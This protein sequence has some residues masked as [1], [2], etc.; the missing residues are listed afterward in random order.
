MLLYEYKKPYI[1]LTDVNDTLFPGN[2]RH[3]DISY[4]SYEELKYYNPEKNVE[5]DKVMKDYMFILNS[6]SLKSSKYQ[7]KSSI[8]HKIVYPGMIEFHNLIHEYSKKDYFNK[9][10]DVSYILSKKKGIGQLIFMSNREQ[11]EL[12]KLES[13]FHDPRQNTRSFT[14]MAFSYFIKPFTQNE[15]PILSSSIENYDIYKEDAIVKK[16]IIKKY[17][18]KF[19]TDNKYLVI[20][21]ISREDMLLNKVFGTEMSNIVD[22][23]CL[24]QI[25]QLND[26]NYKILEKIIKENKVNQLIL[27]DLRIQNNSER[28]IYFKNY[29]DLYKKLMQKT[30]DKNL[31]KFLEENA[32]RMEDSYIEDLQNTKKM[33][34]L[35]I[36]QLI[37]HSKNIIQIIKTFDP[38]NE[39]ETY[40]YFYKLYRR[41]IFYYYLTKYYLNEETNERF[42]N[43]F[44]QY[45]QNVLGFTPTFIN[46]Q[47][48]KTKISKE[49]LNIKS[50]LKENRQS[51]YNI[52]FDPNQQQKNEKK[53]LEGIKI[54]K[55][56]GNR[57]KDIVD[58]KERLYRIILNSYDEIQKY[59]SEEKVY[60]EILSVLYNIL[61]N[62]NIQNVIVA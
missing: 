60:S 46:I 16:E 21:D 45:E 37:D 48:A 7:N 2:T 43:K 19:G 55:N 9:I 51:N 30:N 52:N 14:E 44:H 39:A 29:L 41:L 26:H 31:K 11:K 24:H 61:N 40:V 34:K 27:S 36:Q 32:Y 4:P 25:Y 33:L 38:T 28:V 50:E 1:I 12:L 22:F 8:E 53:Q 35:L 42:A 20:G 49:Y 18:N 59:K 5:L 17:V 62:P 15:Y 13:Y 47:D 58:I 10:H 23:V 3:S 56:Y 6:L 54:I 57:Y